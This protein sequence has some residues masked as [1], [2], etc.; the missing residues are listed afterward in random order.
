MSTPQRQQ[1][2]ANVFLNPDS[3]CARWYREAIQFIPAGTSKANLYMRPHP[4]YVR[5]G[6]G[7]WAT[8]LEGVERL[9][10]VN[11]FTALIHGHAF[12]P[13]VQ[14]VTAQLARGTNFAFSTPEEL[15]LAKLLVERI[16]GLDLVRFGNSGTEA[17]MMAIKAARA[18]T[19]RDRI[20]K[21]EGAYHG[22]YDDVQV[23]FHSTPPAWGPD[24]A[25]ASLASSG[26]IPKHRVQETLVLP[27]N[28]ADSTERLLVRHKNEIAAVIVDP[29]ANRMGFIPPAPGF[30]THLREVT[31]AHGILVIFDE[32]I[33]LRVGYSGAQGRYGGDP[34]L[35]AMGKIIGGG[36]P[37]GA[38]G[39][40]AEVMAVFDPG[41]KGPRILSGG[42]FSANPVTMTAGLAA[43]QAMDRATF[44][45][46]EDM[47]AR[48]RQRLN[49]V[50]RKSGQPGQATGDGSLFRLMT[51]GRPLRNYRD[52]LEPGADARSSRLFMALLDAG[53][54][55][56]D[57]GL[58][59]LSTPMGEAELGRIEAALGRA[60]ATL[61]GG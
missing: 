36:F 16:P 10:C 6:T 15:L 46:L 25:P 35:T 11:N 48:V 32:V 14:A 40:K 9:D 50:F 21:F 29:L 3:Q 59:C 38:T 57:N 22:Y 56:N 44:A 61:A 52:S 58:G 39:G 54:M 4:L 41:T 26:G 18:F 7:C 51:I 33:S 30:L 55:V 19:G 43:M 31:R 8:D 37:V 17:V 13:V 53:I 60:L 23:S 24:D 12:P 5:G 45:R 42:T 47:G 1:T 20:A 27:W 34:D 28:D 2:G 49:E